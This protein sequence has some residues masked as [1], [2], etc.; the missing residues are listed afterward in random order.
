MLNWFRHLEDARNTEELIA[1]VRDHFATWTPEDL[2]LIPPACRPGRMKSA[3]DLEELHAALVEEYRVSK[4]EGD[5]LG[6]LQ[7][8][9]S[10]VVRASMRHAQLH[11][12]D[13]ASGDS[14]A[15]GGDSSPRSAAPRDIQ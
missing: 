15:G 3:R 7:R 10:F 11:E 2:A 13:P 5:E 9:T 4:A 8:L 1:I 12:D 6:A 14:S